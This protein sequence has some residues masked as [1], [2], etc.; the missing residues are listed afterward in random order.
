MPAII[1]GITSQVIAEY[2]IDPDQVFAAGLSAGGAMAVIMGQ[3][4]PNLY[5]AVG[6]HSGLPYQYA[7][8][9][10]SAFTA[11]R[12]ESRIL[13]PQMKPRVIIFHGEADTTVHPSNA[14]VIADARGKQNR[15]LFNGTAIDGRKYARTIIEKN[16]TPLSELWMLQGAGH[17]WSGGSSAG[18]YTDSKGPDASK[19]MVRFFLNRIGI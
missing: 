7:H 10:I 4:Y 11:M 6:V 19:E 8:D 9:V 1:A 14:M 18:S 2:D 17:A 13:F 15:K 3:T 5:A 16:N 12:G